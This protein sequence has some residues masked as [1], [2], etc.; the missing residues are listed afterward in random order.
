[1]TFLTKGEDREFFLTI[2]TVECD[3][4]GDP[5]DLTGKTVTIQYKNNQNLIV[6]LPCTIVNALLGKISFSFNDTQSSQLNN[7]PLPFD[8]VVVEGSDMQIYPVSNKITVRNRN[9]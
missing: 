9:A 1:M 2:K 5:L 8:I 4:V 3:T 6:T 7:G